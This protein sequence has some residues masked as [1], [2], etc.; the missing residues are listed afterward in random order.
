MVKLPSLDKYQILVLLMLGGLGG[1]LAFE[2][3][4][5]GTICGALAAFFGVAA[6]LYYYTSGYALRGRDTKRSD[7]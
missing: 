6:G 3:T 5:I 1:Y 4:V 2:G 7:D